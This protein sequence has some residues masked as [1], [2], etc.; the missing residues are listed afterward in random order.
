[1]TLGGVFVFVEL[2]LTIPRWPFGNDGEKRSAIRSGDGL[3]YVSV[4]LQR[5]LLFSLVTS[6][7]VQLHAEEADISGDLYVRNHL[8]YPRKHC[9][10]VCFVCYQYPRC[11][12][13]NTNAWENYWYCSRS[14]HFLLCA[15]YTIQEV[16]NPAK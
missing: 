12:S 4:T 11:M 8:Y 2:G 3:N 15:A 5:T 13:R 1:M 16:G 10:N 9:W 7:I 6:I 14:K